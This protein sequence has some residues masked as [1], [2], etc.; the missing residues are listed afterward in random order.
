MKKNLY[1]LIAVVM[2]ASIVLAA[3]GGGGTSAPGDSPAPGSG[4]QTQIRW[5]VGLGTGTNPEQISVQEEVVADFN[6][7]QDQIELVLEVVPYDAAYDTLATQL[8]S[9]S[10]PDIVGPVGWS[11][12][13][14][15][16]GQWL[17]LAQYIEESGFDTSIFDPALAASYQTEEGQVGL[18][19]AVFPAAVYY[20][21]AFFDEAGLNYPPSSYGEKYVMPDGS[22]VVWSWDTLRD[23]A[24]LLT[25]DVNGLNSTE[26][27]FD[28]HNIVQVG[29]NP[30]EQTHVLFQG[31]YLA[32]AADIVSGDAPGNYESAIPESW[33]EAN[34]WIYDGM[35]GEQPFIATGPLAAAPEFG[36]GNVFNSA[37]AAMAAMPLWMTCCLEDFVANGNEFQAGAMPVG[38]DGEV[39]SRVDADTYRILKSSK[40]PAEAFTVLSYLITTGA[41]KLLPI[42][43]AMPAIPSKTEAFFATKSEEFPFVTPE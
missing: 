20:V 32:G 12:S 23:I 22:E 9:G 7:S 5:F 42:Y 28:R 39:H 43:G 3:C 19:F 25:V 16:Y 15:F 34:K 26:A 21:P 30:T 27:G 36:N 6:A 18:P 31:T 2:L 40:H 37:K 8:A 24:R 4:E 11:G 13:A 1:T 17:D 29:Y 14:A 38:A 10:G 41:D 33:K 35:W